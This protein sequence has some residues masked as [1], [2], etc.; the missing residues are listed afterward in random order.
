MSPSPS[1][2]QNDI[3]PLYS[4]QELQVRIETLGAEITEAYKDS[5]ALC[6]IGVLRGSFLFFADL[7]RAIDLPIHCDFIGTSSYADGTTSSGVVKIT[8]DLGT[9]I[10]AKDVLVVEDIVDTGLTMQYLLEN[11][12]TRHPASVKL[13]T[14]LDKPDR[15]KVEVQ[16]DYTGFIVP[17]EFVVGYGLD[18]AGKYRNLPY[19]GVYHGET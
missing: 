1:S 5:Q 6:V 15:R 2:W 18:F 19:I 3:T 10:E 17:D 9:N 8:S 14:L 12:R 16:I 7:V 13:C 4:A 11:L